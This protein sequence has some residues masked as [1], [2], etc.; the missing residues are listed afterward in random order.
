MLIIYCWSDFLKCTGRPHFI[1]RVTFVLNWKGITKVF[2]IE[3][4]F[5]TILQI[6][7]DG[8]HFVWS[9]AM[10]I[11]DVVAV[12]HWLRTSQCIIQTM[13]ASTIVHLI[14]LRILISRSKT[15]VIRRYVFSASIIKLCAKA[16]GFYFR[17][18]RVIYINKSPHFRTFEQTPTHTYTISQTASNIT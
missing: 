11:H 2:C 18:L 1:I 5:P 4:L 13:R 7:S 16:S 15:L 8:I 6:I 12:N 10:S 14:F 3:I 9:C 17:N